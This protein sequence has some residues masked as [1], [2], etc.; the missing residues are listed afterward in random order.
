[1]WEERERS[2][3]IREEKEDEGLTEGERSLGTWR[4]SEKEKKE[5]H[6][7]KNNMKE[8]KYMTRSWKWRKMEGG[9]RGSEENGKRNRRRWTEEEDNTTK[10]LLFCVVSV[11]D[12]LGLKG[13]KDIWWNWLGLWKVQN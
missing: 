3:I 5:T 2:R 9:N 6:E 8:M 13:L 12:D 10:S 1:M 4:I 7:E 11:Y